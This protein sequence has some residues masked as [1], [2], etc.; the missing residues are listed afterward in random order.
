M[1]PAA[2]FNHGD[3]TISRQQFCGIAFWDAHGSPYVD[4]H[5][6]DVPPSTTVWRG[7]SIWTWSYLPIIAGKNTIIRSPFFFPLRLR[8]S[9]NLQAGKRPRMCPAVIGHH[10]KLRTDIET[11]AARRG[12]ALEQ[13]SG[14]DQQSFR[15]VQAACGLAVMACPY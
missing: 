14:P 9:V 10:V 1:E 12:H 8:Q 4:S 5:T 2:A 7:L 3:F 6:K 15:R 11:P 13:L